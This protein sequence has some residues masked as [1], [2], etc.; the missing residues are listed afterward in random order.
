MHFNED[1]P[2]FAYRDVDAATWE[3]IVRFY[4]KLSYFR[5]MHALVC[6]IASSQ[7]SEVLYAKT[8]MQS[9]LLAQS[10]IFRYWRLSSASHKPKRAQRSDI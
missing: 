4:E 7:L 3:S 8:S 10:P 2:R 5:P 1:P 9:L 6:A